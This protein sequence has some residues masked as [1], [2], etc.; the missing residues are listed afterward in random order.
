MLCLS[1]LFQMGH[2][3]CMHPPPVI[4]TLSPYSASQDPICLDLHMLDQT[5][6]AVLVISNDQGTQFLG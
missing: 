1:T 2:K 4:L 5:P 3:P 6:L